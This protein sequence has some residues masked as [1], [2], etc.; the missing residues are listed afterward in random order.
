MTLLLTV[1]A[2]SG[3]QDFRYNSMAQDAAFHALSFLEQHDH[4]GS[5]VELHLELDNPEQVYALLRWISHLHRDTATFPG[6]Y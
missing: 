3:D 6:P 1:G 2:V 5:S 4:E